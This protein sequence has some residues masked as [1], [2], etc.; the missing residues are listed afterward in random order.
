M[1]DVAVQRRSGAKIMARLIVLLG[2]LAYVMVLAVANGALGF[3]CAMGVTLMGAVGVA[4]ALG[5]SIALSYGAII[6]LAVGC[7]FMR[8]ILR[9]IEQY[10]N[11][12]I[13]FNLLAVLRDRILRPCVRCALRSSKQRKRVTSSP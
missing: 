13:A 11:H 1:S 2:S 8:G 7:G 4:K 6:A 5:E 12:Y 9:Y 10:F 3:I